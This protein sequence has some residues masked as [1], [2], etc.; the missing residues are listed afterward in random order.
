MKKISLLLL[1]FAILISAKADIRHGGN[2]GGEAEMKVLSFYNSLK[3]WKKGCVENPGICNVQAEALAF[4]VSTRTLGYVEKKNY[5]TACSDQSLW[6]A[7]EDLYQPMIENKADIPKKDSE[8]LTELLKSV[9]KCQGRLN[10]YLDLSHLKV[11]PSHGDVS[12]DS[13]AYLKGKYT[14][15]L[16]NLNSSQK[17][18]SEITEAIKCDQYRVVSAGK[19]FINVKCLSNPSYYNLDYEIT[20]GKVKITV[21]FQSSD[22]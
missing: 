5:T 1:A 16:V 12:L 4:D 11:F 22:F 7:Y 14:D 6:L 13:I 2:G 9:L 17:L 10:F 15:V 20:S 3:I 18:H 8:L 21:Y 19:R